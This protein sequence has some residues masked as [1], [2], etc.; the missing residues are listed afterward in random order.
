MLVSSRGCS[1]LAWQVDETLS[2]SQA[3]S[4]LW[5]RADERV[6]EYPNIAGGRPAMLGGRQNVFRAPCWR[7]LLITA[8][9]LSLMTRTEAQPGASNDAAMSSPPPPPSSSLQARDLP[10]AVNSKELMAAHVAR[11]GGKVCVM[12]VCDCICACLYTHP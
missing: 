7:C 12:S 9:L 3:G 2:D 6:E 11:T 10:S 5:P 4:C 1:R 8:R